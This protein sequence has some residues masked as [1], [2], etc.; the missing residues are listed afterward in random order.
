[1]VKIYIDPGHG[2]TDPGASANGLKEKDLTL[3]IATRVKNMLV[4]EY[5]NATVRMS[6]TGDQTV[7]LPQRTNDANA[8]GANY[9]LSIHIN[10]GGGTG[11]EDYI[12]NLL[13][14]SS[15]T[16]QL[17]NTIHAEI[18]KL[19]DMP[20]RGKKKE[21]FHVLRESRMPAMLTENGFIDNATDAAKMKTSAWLDKAARGHVNG[22]AKALG[23]Q[24]VSIPPP[25]GNVL[26]RV[27]TGSFTTRANADQQ[28][29]ALKAKGF[30]SFIDIA[31]VNGITY[32]RVIT[33][34]FADKSN[35]DKQVADLK[36]K[37]FDAF[38]IVVNV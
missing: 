36:A 11:Y 37:G 3:A 31:V 2:G 6:R 27:V 35:A 22:L 16:A 28:V 30:D 15:T 9:Y 14:D 38:I 10:A 18:V 21:N 23:L 13:S 32:Y 7:D 24:K 26:Y 34:S 33:G 1:M 25:T 19:I 5:S 29:A 20:N 8:W 4:N 17:R 12:H